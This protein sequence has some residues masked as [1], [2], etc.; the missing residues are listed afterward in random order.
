MYFS[1]F[2]YDEIT[3]LFMLSCKTLFYKM[4]SECDIKGFG[5]LFA[6]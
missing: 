5:I 3:L 2:Y 6:F 1:L 4:G